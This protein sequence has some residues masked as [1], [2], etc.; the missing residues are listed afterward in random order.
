MQLIILFVVLVYA[1]G[2]VKT[3]A[4]GFPTA[5]ACQTVEDIYWNQ[6]A[7]V[8]KKT[9]VVSMFTECLNVIPRKVDEE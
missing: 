2:T 1:D 7:E 5:E 6:T 9:K 8:Y 4:E 3:H